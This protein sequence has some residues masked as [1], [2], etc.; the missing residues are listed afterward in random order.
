MRRIAALNFILV[1]LLASSPHHHPV[2]LWSASSCNI[3]CCVIHKSTS[4]FCKL[5]CWW[6]NEL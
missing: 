3:L 4:Y 2:T 5:F 6:T 1:V